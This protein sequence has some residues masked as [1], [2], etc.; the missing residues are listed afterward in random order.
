MNK[1]AKV[2]VLFLCICTSCGNTLQNQFPPSPGE[3][4]KISIAPNQVYDLSGY[5]D[6]GGGNPYRLFDE[7]AFV[8]P[9]YEKMT[10]SFLPVTNCQPT[11]HPAIYF[12]GKEGNRIVVD[13]RI[14]Y[15]I[16]EIYFFDRSNGVDSFWIY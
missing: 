12:R 14:P 3:L 8:D 15:S 11:I 2:W 5:A 6:E 7:N 10:D 16:R 9:R 1:R 4:Q 13:L